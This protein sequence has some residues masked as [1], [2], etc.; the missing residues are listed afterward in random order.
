MALVD[1]ASGAQTKS[2]I[3]GFAE[4]EF[5]PRALGAVM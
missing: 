3:L 5:T 1:I 4:D 2:E